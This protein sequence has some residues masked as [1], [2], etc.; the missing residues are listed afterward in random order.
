LSAIISAGKKPGRALREDPA[1][2]K[3]T[4]VI[5]VK[6]TDMGW[7]IRAVRTSSVGDIKLPFTG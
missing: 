4:L 3:L 2:A 7:T 5:Q 6:Y 1:A